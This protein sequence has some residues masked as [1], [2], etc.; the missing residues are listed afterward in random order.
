[1]M[2]NPTKSSGVVIKVSVITEGDAK[3][4]VQ[5]SELKDCQDM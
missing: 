1:M 2:S 5:C 4:N 3:V